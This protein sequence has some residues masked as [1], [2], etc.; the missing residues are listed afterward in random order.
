MSEQPETESLSIDDRIYAQ[1]ADEQPEVEAPAEEQQPTEEAAESEAQPEF[2]DIEFEGK[3]YQVPP[4]LKDA[5]LRQSDYTKKTTEVSERQRALEQKEL[6]IKAAEA[7]KTFRDS[8]KDDIRAIDRLDYQIEQYKSVDVTGM[9]AEELWKLS[10]HIEKLNSDK[11]QL[12]NG[13]NQKWHGFQQQQQQLL[14]DAKAKAEEHVSKA[15]KGWGPEAKKAVRDFAV[16]QGFTQAEIDSIGDPRVVN[17][18]WKAAQFDKLQSQ[19]IQGKVKAVPT[20][21]PGSS[22][23]MPQAVKDQFALKKQ[24]NNPKLSS[25][26]KAKAI[27]RELMN[28]F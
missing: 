20:V 15:I 10:R 7:E 14:A 11:A 19:N 27:E 6:Q 12:A 21:K 25:S 9:S 4:E 5:I 13:L 17:T 2:V 23:P 18:L 16:N 24:L 22:N 8:V 26:Q 3:A 28:R 1:F